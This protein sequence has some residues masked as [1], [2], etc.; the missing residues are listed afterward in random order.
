[1]NGAR[2]RR[3]V[4]TDAGD[5]HPLAWWAWAGGLAVAAWRT[6][7]P[8][9]LVLIAAAAVTVVS[10]RRSSE[11]W[12]GAL[13]LSLRF[14]I[15]VV[16]IRIV[17]QIIFGARTGGHTLFSLPQVPL[18]GWA[19]GVSIGG[20]V[21]LEAL[22]ASLYL[23]LQLATVLVCFGAANSL[24]SPYRLLRCLPAVFYEAG[25]AVTVGLSFTPAAVVTVGELRAARRLRG[26]PVRG[27]AG[28]R[29]MAVPVLEGTLEHALDLAASMDARG[30]GRHRRRP[31]RVARLADVATVVGLLA[32]AGGI[33]GILDQAG[34]P[35][36]LGPVALAVGI[37]ALVG[38]LAGRGR[39]TAR[40][41]Y[42][43]DRWDVA[44]W[45]TLG[46][47]ALLVAA[48]VAA[49]AGLHPGTD[50]VVAPGLPVI[51]AVALLASLV[52]LLVTR[53]P[54]PLRR[55]VADA[56]AA[57]TA[58]AR[59]PAPWTRPI[60]GP[61]SDGAPAAGPVSDG[62]PEAEAGPV[63]VPAWARRAAPETTR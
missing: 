63:A 53:A 1:V 20:P 48:F 23:G 47:A 9:V 11:A 22:L 60:D 27:I 43:P 16:S 44:A 15:V 29:G 42:R 59:P 30:Y 49:P 61:V 4:R 37:V 19:A 5:L 24:A 28:L 34:A 39:R 17:L 55:T 50:P 62:A 2:G 25:V 35:R 13:R 14:A 10:L 38:G 31:G 6:T 54:G 56:P 41:R 3:P 45:V 46:G 58:G 32:L 8:L 12:S 18:P 40:S 51:T 57:A 52:P 7:D 26:R 33:F 36:H 21:T